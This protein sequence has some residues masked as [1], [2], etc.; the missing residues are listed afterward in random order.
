MSNK[1]HFKHKMEDIEKDRRYEYCE[2]LSQ[3]HSKALHDVYRQT[4]LKTLA[5]R[6]VSGQLQGRLLSFLVHIFKPLHIL[7]IGTFSGYATL[8]LAEGLPENG[9]I[10]SIEVNDEFEYLIRKH[11][12]NCPNKK[13]IELKFG[14]ALDVIPT[15][16]SEFDLVFIDAKKLDYPLYYD[17]VFDKVSSGG[18]IIF[19]NVLWSNK[20]LDL[21]EHKDPRTQTLHELNLRIKNDSRVENFILPLRDGLQIVRKI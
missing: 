7:E 13:N 16:E 19:D 4:H 10:T 14:S 17:L 2:R 9:K 5:P 6:M 21:D 18:V 15:L 12:E 11:L 3:D 20:V 8:C 1:L